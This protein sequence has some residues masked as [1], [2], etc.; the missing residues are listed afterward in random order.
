MFKKCH[1]DAEKKNATFCHGKT[2]L[3]KT[4]NKSRETVKIFFFFNVIFSSL[5]DPIDQS[6][7][8]LR[9]VSRNL[10]HAVN[11]CHFLSDHRYINEF[12]WPDWKNNRKTHLKK[13]NFMYN[14]KNNF[15]TLIY[16]LVNLRDASSLVL[17][18]LHP[19]F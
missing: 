6:E 13:E 12:K 8:E 2:H 16:F 14:I 19:R 3:E 4:M 10:H 5:F 15:V 17:P 1:P 11:H 7:A 18:R 9:I